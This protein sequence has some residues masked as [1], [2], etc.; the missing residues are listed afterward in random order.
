MVNRSGLLIGLILTCLLLSFYTTSD[1]FLPFKKVEVHAD[2]KQV[3]KDNFIAVS[4]QFVSKG[5]LRASLGQL[6]QQFEQNK[7]IQSVEISRQW[8]SGLKIVLIEKKPIARWGEKE[9]MDSNG[10]RLTPNSLGDFESL[11]QLIGEDGQELLV[12][13]EYQNISQIFD[14]IGQKVIEY[15]VTNRF[16]RQLKLSNGITINIG[17]QSAEQRLSRFIDVYFAMFHDKFDNISYI[18]LRYPKGLAVRFRK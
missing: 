17:Q 6:K 15:E 18:D 9:L 12:L 8:P 11:P 14:K 1:V 3:S 13:K 2:F 10:E 7:W 4:S 16:S 5:I